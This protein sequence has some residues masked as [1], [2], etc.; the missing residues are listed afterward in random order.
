[1]NNHWKNKGIPGPEPELL[2]GNMRDIWEYEKPR[3]L[4]IRDW[5]KKYG[6][7]QYINWRLSIQYN[8]P[9]SDV[10]ILWGSSQVSSCLWL[11]YAQWNTRQEFRPFLCKSS[12]CTLH[13]IRL[14]LFSQRFELQKTKDG[15]KTHLVDSRGAHWKRLRA[16]GSYAFTNKALKQVRIVH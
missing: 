3:S 8:I 1:M 7:V 4:V 11:W 5:S 14:F 12:E 9:L 6:K 2:F 15:P 13:P 10:W 16:L